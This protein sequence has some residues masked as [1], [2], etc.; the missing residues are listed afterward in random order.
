[1]K[2]SKVTV[3]YR[4]RSENLNRYL[5]LPRKCFSS[6]YTAVW[7]SSYRIARCEE[8]AGL[9]YGDAL[10]FCLGTQFC[11]ASAIDVFRS[12]SGRLYRSASSFCVGR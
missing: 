7:L 8:E 2:N 4:S 5:S 12:P 3:V 1:M 9:S 11:E 6:D 10:D